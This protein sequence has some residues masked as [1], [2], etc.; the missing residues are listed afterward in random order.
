[1]VS[2]FFNHHGSHFI[3]FV[4]NRYEGLI[5]RRSLSRAQAQLCTE[6]S[7]QGHQNTDSLSLK[8]ENSDDP[9]SPAPS[10]PPNPYFA[11]LLEKDELTQLRNRGAVFSN[12]KEMD[13]RFP[14]TYRLKKRPPLSTTEAL[15]S[16]VNP[17][18]DPLTGTMRLW[19]RHSLEF[20]NRHETEDVYTIEIWNSKLGTSTK[21]IPSYTD[22]IIFYSSSD[23]AAMLVPEVSWFGAS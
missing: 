8:A 1:M 6:S 20:T 10:H 23:K 9:D 16:G 5:A 21:R 19:H 14:P 17:P 2:P 7:G 12:F 4:Y 18:R 13:I 15:E 22:R 11:S 3:L